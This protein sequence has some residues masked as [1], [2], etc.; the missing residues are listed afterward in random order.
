MT[1]RRTSTSR[2]RGGDGVAIFIDTGIFIAARNVSDKHHDTAV[3][4]LVKAINGEFGPVYTSDYIFDEA[5]TLASVRVKQ[6]E[7][8][9]DIGEY[10]LGFPALH[11]LFTGEEIFRSAWDIHGKYSDKPFSFTDCTI[12]A[13]CE[14]LGIQLIGTVDSHFDGIL[15]RA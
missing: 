14:Q 8:V 4:L 3:E 13:W 12:L 2:S 5:I 9:R 6:K 15:T 11:L 7:F 1:A 10:I